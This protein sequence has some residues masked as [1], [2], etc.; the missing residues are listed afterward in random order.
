VTFNRKIIDTY[1]YDSLDGPGDYVITVDDHKSTRTVL[2]SIKQGD[3][4]PNHGRLPSF[5]FYVVNGCDSRTVVAELLPNK[6]NIIEIEKLPA[7]ICFLIRRV[8]DCGSFA[9]NFSGQN[10]EA[11]AVVNPWVPK[12]G[13]YALFVDPYSDIGYSGRMGNRIQV[14]FE[15]LKEKL[16]LV[17]RIDQLERRVCLLENRKIVRFE[18]P[19]DGIYTFDEFVYV[20][21][22]R[23]DRV[24]LKKGAKYFITTCGEVK[25]KS[26]NHAGSL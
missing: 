6:V 8:P 3:P 20:G 12:P 22:I 19:E 9:Y 17:G 7:T 10:I 11:N 4:P 18:A 1:N 16:D 14:D 13:K 2:L 5:L 25:W 26:D 23:A 21:D 15:I 24:T